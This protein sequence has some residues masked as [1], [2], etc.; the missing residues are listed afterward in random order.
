MRGVTI[1]RHTTLWLLL[2]ALSGAGLTTSLYASPVRQIRP[3]GQSWLFLRQ[4]LAN[5]GSLAIDDSGWERIDLPHTYNA[6]D[7]TTSTTFYRGPAWYRRT[8]VLASTLLDRH[9]YIEFDGVTLAADLWVNGQKVGGHEGG[10]ARFRFD[11]TP[12]LKTGENQLAVRV[13]NSKLPDV[14]PLGGDFTVFGGIYRGVRLVTT[15]DIHFDMLDYGGPGVY[16]K[17]PEVTKDEAK[18][19]WL[20]R[21]ANDRDIATDVKLLIHLVDTRHKVVATVTRAVTL[22]PNKVT[23]VSLNATFARPHLWQGVKDPYLYS[24]TAELVGSDSKSTFL[25]RIKFPVGIREVQLDPQKGLLLNGVPYAVHG[26]DIHQTVLPHKGSAVTDTDIDADYKILGELGVTGL[27]FAHYQHAPHEYDLADQRG[28]LVWTEAPLVSEVN[29]SEGFSSNMQ[30]QLRELIRQNS[31]H[32]SV[33]VWGLGNEIYKVDETS[34]KVLDAMQ[35]VAHGEDSSRPTTYANCC[36]DIDGSQASHTDAVGSNVYFGWYS[37]AFSDL[38]PWLDNNHARVPRT[39]I[40]V[41]EYGAG[42]SIFQEEDPTAR[43]VAGSRWHPEQYQ[44]LYHEAAWDQIKTKPYLWAAFVWVGFDFPSAGRNEGDRPGFND[45]GLVTFDRKTRKDAFYWYQANWSSSPV[46]YITS[47]RMTLRTKSEVE[48]KAY[49]NRC[50]LT[51]TLNG[52]MISEHSVVDHIA[53]WRITLSKGVNDI[54]VRDGNVRDKVSWTYVSQ[55]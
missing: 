32:P 31:N 9:T 16:F 54:E 12:F 42:G 36:N 41:S 6:I 24:T 55:P 14:A 13:D 2:I 45:K 50:T 40:A 7:G 17:T 39:P 34:A 23:L 30:Q 27:R 48:V 19:N 28:Y 4:D 5:G 18:L 26:V 3:L 1:S 11:I 20:V 10:F 53:R 37:G 29:S 46:I 38:G 49:S 15:N 35:A 25:D 33:M 21:I 22:R 47:R 51:L 8:V 44:A 52:K 43:S